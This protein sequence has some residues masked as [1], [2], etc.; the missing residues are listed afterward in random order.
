MPYIYIYI[1]AHIYIYIYRVNI[2]ICK[3]NHEKHVS[4]NTVRNV[5]L[6]ENIRLKHKRLS[7]KI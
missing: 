7:Y 6:R 1:K 2:Y 5:L 4:S 3:Q